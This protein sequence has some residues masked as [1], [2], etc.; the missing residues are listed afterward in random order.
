M[1]IKLQRAY[2]GFTDKA[3]AVA[4]LSGIWIPRKFCLNWE[5]DKEGETKTP[6]EVMECELP[7]WFIN[8]NPALIS[9]SL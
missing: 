8:K 3:F 2:A 4:G 7:D 1:R 5:P 9:K 6:P